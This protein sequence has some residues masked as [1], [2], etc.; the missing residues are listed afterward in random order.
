MPIDRSEFESGKVLTEIEK[1]VISFLGRNR[2]NAFTLVE[3]MDGINFQTSFRDF[4]RTIISGIA[5]V[6]F[7]SFLNNL[8]TSG[9]IRVN[10]IQGTY[11]Y[12]AK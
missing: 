3:I 4:W 9:K 1:A 8:A 12:M 10:I 7:Q 5:I 11:Y 6:T 2:N